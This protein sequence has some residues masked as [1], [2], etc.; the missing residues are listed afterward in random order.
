MP[1]ETEDSSGVS[2]GS[3]LPWHPGSSWVS[4]SPYLR[5]RQKV[6]LSINCFNWSSPQGKGGAWFMVDKEWARLRAGKWAGGDGAGARNWPLE[7]TWI[8]MPPGEASL[9][10]GSSLPWE[11]VSFLGS[12]CFKVLWHCSLS[13]RSWHSAGYVEIRTKHIDRLEEGCLFYCCFYK[14]N[15]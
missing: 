13:I 3:V 4:D 6:F 9:W 1:G 10:A 8:W 5:Q 14:C 15:S 2:G 12:P 11:E 7:A